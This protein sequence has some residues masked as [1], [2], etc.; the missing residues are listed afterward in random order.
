MLYTNRSLHHTLCSPNAAKSWQNDVFP[1]IP[2]IKSVKKSVLMTQRFILHFIYHV[3]ILGYLEI[4]NMTYKMLFEANPEDQYQTKICFVNT[5]CRE[6]HL[7]TL[8]CILTERV[9]WY[10]DKSPG[11]SMPLRGISGVVLDYSRLDGGAAPEPG[12]GGKFVI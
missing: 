5:F 8:Q 9:A 6:G 7:L 3:D 10:G 2:I 1:N 4:S 12:R 11:N